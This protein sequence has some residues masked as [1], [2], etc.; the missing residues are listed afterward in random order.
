MGKKQFSYEGIIHTDYRK[1]IL[2]KLTAILLPFFGL[3]TLFLFTATYG[4]GDTGQRR[5]SAGN[6]PIEQIIGV[7]ELFAWLT[8][9][10]VIIPY[11]IIIIITYVSLSVYIRNFTFIVSES[12]IVIHHGVFTKTKATIP[13]INIQNINIVSGVFDRIF[14]LYTVKIETAGASRGGASTSAI[15]V[16]PEGHIPG[17]KD[18]AIIE[19]KINEMMKKH[20]LIPTALEEKIFKPEE[21]AF[22]N[23]ISYI[24]SKMREGGALKTNIKSL[25]EKRNLT[26]AQ[27]ANKVEVPINTIKY[28]EEG[29]YNPSLTLAYKIAQALECKIEDLFE[30]A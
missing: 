9:F 4:N 8:L 2:V 13:Y 7:P 16:R 29:S 5:P 27:L 21:V 23:F 3:I 10:I 19:N 30:L 17:V 11:L 15:Q 6:G 12:S 20:S 18:P 1:K 25:R 24:L 28:L 26:V 14:K 22:D